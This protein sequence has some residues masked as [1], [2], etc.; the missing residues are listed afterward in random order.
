MAGMYDPFA[1]PDAPEFIPAHIRSWDQLNERIW[2]EG[3]VHQIYI[4]G[5]MGVYCPGNESCWVDYDEGLL[6]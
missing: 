6:Y 2:V 5:L 3:T 4:D 1:D